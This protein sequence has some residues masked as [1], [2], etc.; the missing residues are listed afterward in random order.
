M[1]SSSRGHIWPI[2]VTKGETERFMCRKNKA[3]KRETERM[4]WFGKIGKFEGGGSRVQPEGL[5]R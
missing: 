1:G 4:M 2:Y 3:R 5:V